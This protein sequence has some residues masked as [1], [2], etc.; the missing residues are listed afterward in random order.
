[1]AGIDSDLTDI[2]QKA[3]YT[4]YNPKAGLTYNLKP[5][6]QLYA[7]FAIGNREPV[8]NDFTDS[9]PNSRPT[10][11]TLRNLEAGYRGRTVLGMAGSREVSLDA[12]LNYF[13]MDYKNQLVLTG[14]INDVGG[15]NRTNIKESYR[16]GIELAGALNLGTFATISSNV[17]YSKNRIK[18]FSEFIDDYDTGEQ[19]EN[20]FAESTIAFS[21]ELVS[22]SRLE[23][24]VLKG[25]RAA[26][27]YKTVSQQ[28]LDNTQ[29]EKR[30]IP[31]Y[32][33]A[34][35]RLRY[36]IDFKK[37]LKSLELGLLVNNVFNELYAANGY[38]YSYIYDATQITEN[39]YYPQATRNF[40]VSVGLRF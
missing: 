34:D 22:T 33:I 11:E 5:N 28:Y 27:I 20:Q 38:T 7:S 23:V 17:A 25:L 31:A 9:S 12:E 6:Q 13:L 16:Q 37:A 30:I 10:H 8:R 15:Y 36:N 4:F 2:T 21:P 32:Q 19:V 14:E 3:E 18:N 40:L 26:F 39:F 24:E 1:M 29:N 35:V